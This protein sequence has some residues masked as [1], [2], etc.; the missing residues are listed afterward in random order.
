MIPKTRLKKQNSTVINK[1]LALYSVQYKVFKT[2]HIQT[3]VQV[4]GHE[5]RVPHA[6]RR[7][8]RKHYDVP[9]GLNPNPNLNPTP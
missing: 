3:Q 4:P 2:K 7:L 8:G 5:P 9:S 6:H 1:L